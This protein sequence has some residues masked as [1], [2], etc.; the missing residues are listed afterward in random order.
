MEQKLTINAENAESK[1][2]FD[3]YNLIKEGVE[4]NGS[5]CHWKCEKILDFRGAKICLIFGYLTYDSTNNVEI[6][7]HKLCKKYL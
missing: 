1:K 4:Y 6:Q 7:R 2:H 3:F 5:A